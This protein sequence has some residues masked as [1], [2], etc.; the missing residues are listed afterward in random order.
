MNLEVP[1]FHQVWEVLSYLPT[2]LSLLLV[3]L[4]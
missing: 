1:G 2:F 3:G 4:H